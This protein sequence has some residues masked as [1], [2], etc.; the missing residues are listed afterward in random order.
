MF[1]LSYM[2]PVIS[3]GDIVSA[4]RDWN[5]WSLV[6]QRTI[7][8]YSG[9]MN[10]PEIAYEVWNEPDLFGQWKTYGEKNYLDLYRF[11][12]SG[13]GRAKVKQNF[14]LG[15][16]ATTAPYTAWTKNFLAFVSQNNLRLDFFSWH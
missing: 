6:V 2:P 8:H 1:A 7:E 11:A 3:S 5:E 15:G 14:K 4:P 13:A 16:P 9:N 12:A 10:V